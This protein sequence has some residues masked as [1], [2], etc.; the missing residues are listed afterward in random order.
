MMLAINRSRSGSR[1]AMAASLL[2]FAE[3]AFEESA[4]GRA[5]S[6]GDRPGIGL[7]RLGNPAQPLE[8]VGTDGVE[9]L[10]FLKSQTIHNGQCRGGTFHLR[11]GNGPVQGHDRTRGERQQ[12]VIEL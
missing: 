2:V 1:S 12:L 4:L 6:T 3:A 7:R 8:K 11:Y 5:G 10:V 9:R